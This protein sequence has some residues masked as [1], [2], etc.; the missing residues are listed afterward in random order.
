VDAQPDGP[1]PIGAP[2]HGVRM[3]RMLRQDLPEVAALHLQALP[4]S[5]FASLGPRFLRRYYESFLVS[6][7]GIGLVATRE[8]RM[9]GFV[10]GSADAADHSAWVVRHCGLRL[11]AAALVAMLLR[12]RV[13]AHFLA[14]R[15]AR[16][17]RGVYR[18]L[19]HQ[20]DGEAAGAVR[21]DQPAVLAHVA[22]HSAWRR[23]GLGEVLVRAFE[24]EARA[25]GGRTVELV[26][27]DG[28]EGAGRFYER[29]GY[30]TDRVRRDDDGRRWR[31][32]RSE[33]GL[34]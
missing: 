11:A 8:G 7:H 22:V 34:R 19:R 28:P 23:K 31:Y 3:T 12:P 6:P 10:I 20:A 1:I 2:I 4:P 27:L 29:L 5:F 25:R 30:V 14:T 21:S 13:L 24:Q 9:C 17:T 32:F 26:T 33:P 16:Y 15:G 18:R